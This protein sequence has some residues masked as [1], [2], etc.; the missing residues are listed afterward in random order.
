M[1]QYRSV[2]A[3]RINNRMTQPETNPLPMP[4]PPTPTAQPPRSCLSRLFG[5]IGWLLTVLIAAGLA[6]AV[7]AGGL[8]LLGIDL[9]T[10]Q[11]IRQ[12]NTEVQRLQAAATVQADTIGQLQTAQAQNRTEMGNARE[13]IDELEAQARQL[14]TAATAQ[15]EYAATAVAL[16]R[17]LQTAVAEAAVLQDQLREGQVV[18]AVVATVQATQSEQIREIEQRSARLIRFLDRLSDI[19]ADTADDTRLPTPAATATTIP[20]TATPTITP[21]VTPTP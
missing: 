21:A 6:L 13:R 12:A 1:L 3:Q 18:V 7:A 16:G 9:T 19:A 15:A 11:Q 2:R 8:Y 17:A 4:A 20:F 5:F 10:P 14:A